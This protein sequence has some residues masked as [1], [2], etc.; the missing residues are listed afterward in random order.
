M[1]LTLRTLSYVSP[2]FPRAGLLFVL[3]KP[4]LFLKVNQVQ[5]LLVG[6][7]EANSPRVQLGFLQPVTSH[8]SPML[9][10]TRCTNV[11]SEIH[12]SHCSF[13]KLEADLNISLLNVSEKHQ[14]G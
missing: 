3:W 4:H 12:S 14:H 11:T 9:N 2:G 7:P 10:L 8:S 6:V 13:H 1:P 5:K